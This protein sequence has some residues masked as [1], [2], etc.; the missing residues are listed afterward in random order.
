MAIEKGNIEDVDELCAIALNRKIYHVAGESGFYILVTDGALVRFRPAHVDSDAS[1]LQ[2][3]LGMLVS[4]PGASGKW[5]ATL[6][7]YE[8]KG[9]SY[10]ETVSA[11]GAAIG[12]AVRMRERGKR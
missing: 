4:P 9:S 7:K 1:F 5:S 10:C 8:T 3:E 11:L 12:T 2:A 6:G